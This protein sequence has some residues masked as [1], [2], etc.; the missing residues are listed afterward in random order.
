MVP[1]VGPR[2]LLALIFLHSI[3]ID[4]RDNCPNV[5]EEH[6]LLLR[7]L[8]IQQE[9]RAPIFHPHRWLGMSLVMWQG[10]SLAAQVQR[11]PQ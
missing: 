4:Q 9:L 10:V 8:S 2:Y 7:R 5:L 11:S 1:T 3:E 6:T